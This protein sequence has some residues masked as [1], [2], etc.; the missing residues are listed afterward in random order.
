MV[1]D[2]QQKGDWGF[3]D[4]AKP[5]ATAS[6]AEDLPLDRGASNASCTSAVSTCGSPLVRLQSRI[7]HSWDG[8]LFAGPLCSHFTLRGGKSVDAGH[9]RVKRGKENELRCYTI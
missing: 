4:A 9:R 3:C 5:A 2:A 8:E 1:G 7:R 6:S